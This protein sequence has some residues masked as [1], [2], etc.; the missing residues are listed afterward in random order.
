[1]NTSNILITEMSLDDLNSI[2]NILETEFDDFWNYSIFK[3]ELENPH[4]KYFVLKKDNEIIGF[5]GILIIL[6]EAEITNIVIKKTLRSN[7]FSKFL[8]D[9]IINYCSCNNISKIHLEVNSSNLIAINLYKNFGFKEVGLRK[10][11]YKNCDA[12]LLTKLITE[13]S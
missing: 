13:A 5:A 11:Y 12:I 4:S 3:T 6:D 1:M 7:G 9:T 8:M 2:K 10:N